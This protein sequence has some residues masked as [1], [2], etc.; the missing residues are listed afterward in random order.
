MFDTEART[1]ERAILV[2]VY[3]QRAAL[4]P[5]LC[6]EELASLVSAAGGQSVA[7]L[8]QRRSGGK[9]ESD[10]RNS[11]H[12]AIDPAT[13]IGRGKAAQVGA[14][15]EAHDAS[16]VVFDNELSPAQIRELETI[17][18]CK[19]I[20]RTELILDIF[21]ARAQ[22]REAMLQVELAQLEY[23][24][25]RLRGMWT[26]LERQA[27]SG[28]A[29]A[30]AGI[31][32][33]GPGEKQIEIDRRI[34]GKRITRLRREL[35]RIEARKQR[36]VAHRARKGY[37]VGLI[38]YTNAGK[39]TLLNRVAD[40]GTYSADQ[41]FATLATKT[42]LWRLAPGI[43]VLLSDTVGFV[44]DLP[45]GLVASF[46]STLEE[47]IHADLLL[48]VIDASHPQALEQVR[49]VEDVLRQLDREDAPTLYVL[50]KLDNVDDQD[51]LIALRHRL[52]DAV[53]ISAATGEGMH[54]LVAAVVARR[55]EQWLTVH[56]H[57][58]VS[59][60]RLRSLVHEHAHVSS[61]H[62]V[63]EEWI[64]EISLSKA[65][66]SQQPEIL[67]AVCADHCDHSGQS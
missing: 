62:Y 39:S 36:E 4:A 11:E 10:T 65:Q 50:N 1:H 57:A 67:A 53:E 63:D 20:D 9:S 41:L 47:T 26:H 45:P 54:E 40:A 35:S 15:V 60:G 21:A 33:R 7:T 6:L 64:A 30:S 46:R 34:I 32:T 23:T 22:T 42:K 25:P 59:N 52:K 13:F 16:I 44:R 29:G 5:E 66:L 43:D 58:S 3:S 28:G 37:C 2:G 14:L 17:V 38:G 18:G 19:V 31:G 49:A 56:V 55:C 12:R 8:F 48:H 61:E 51:S 27:A 24:A